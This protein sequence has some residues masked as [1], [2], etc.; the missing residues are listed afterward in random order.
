M[1]KEQAA[2]IARKLEFNALLA[3]GVRRKRERE[4]R[5]HPELPGPTGEEVEINY[6]RESI[7]DAVFQL[8]LVQL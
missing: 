2:Q 7:K 5:K 1:S 6:L 8:R 4:R 3:E